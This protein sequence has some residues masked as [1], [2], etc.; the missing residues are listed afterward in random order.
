VDTDVVAAILKEKSGLTEPSDTLVQ[1]SDEIIT[2]KDTEVSD[3]DSLEEETE[4]IVRETLESTDSTE[5]ESS[6]EEDQDTDTHKSLQSSSDM[7]SDIGEDIST[8]TTPRDDDSTSDGNTDQDTYPP[9]QLKK[10]TT[11]SMAESRTDQNETDL[12]EP[13][14][15]LSEDQDEP[16]PVN[17]MQILPD[18]EGS[19]IKERHQ[20]EEPQYQE[21]KYVEPQFEN[22]Q[23]EE[24][25]GEESQE[26]EPDDDE[27]QDDNTGDAGNEDDENRDDKD[28]DNEP[29]EPDTEDDNGGYRV[30]M[31]RYRDPEIEF[32]E[33]SDEENSGDGPGGESKDDSDSGQDDSSPE[34]LVT[35]DSEF[36]ETTDRTTDPDVSEPGS[37]GDDEDSFI[38]KDEEDSN[39]D[40][41]HETKPDDPLQDDYDPAD[42]STTDESIGEDGEQ[43]VIEDLD[44]P[45]E[46]GDV[47]S[48][49][50]S[51]MSWVPEQEEESIPRK[52]VYEILSII[53][54]T[55]WEEIRDSVVFL[56]HLLF[57]LLIV[58]SGAFLFYLPFLNHF[59][60]K[61]MGIGTLWEYRQTTNMDGFLT[62][63]GLF[64]FIMAT[65]LVKW[66]FSVHRQRGLSHGRILGTGAI[67]LSIY[68]AAIF[69]FYKYFEIDY[70]VLILSIAMGL[71][72]LSIIFRGRLK[73]DQV[74][75][76]MLALVAVAITAGVE[77]FFIKDFYQGGDHRRFNTVFKF[78]LQAWFLLAIASAFLVAH[79]SKIS[80]NKPHS[81][82]MSMLR[83]FGGWIW[84]M[85]FFTL[86]A[87]A[88]IFTFQGPRARRH[89]DEYR[90]IDLP[91][92]LDGMAYMKQGV[93]KNEHRAIMWLN[94]NVK[95][96]PVILEVSGPDYQYKYGKISAN[97]GLPTVL[98]WW[99]HVDQREYKRNTG[100]MKRD[101]VTIY[102]SLDIPKVLDLL[103]MYN[104]EY[105]Y[106]GVT[107]K[108]EYEATGLEKF[109]DLTDYMTP[110]YANSDVT[111]YRVN[112]YG[113]NVD[114]A[115]VASD[116]DALEKLNQRLEQEAARKAEDEIK[117]EEARRKAMEKMK[118]RN[119]LNAGKGASR[120]MFEEP[121][122][123]DVDADGNVYVADFR[124]H[125]IQKFNKDGEWQL[126]WGSSGNG[127]GQFH[128]VC[129]VTVDSDGVYVADTF[130]NRIQKF[131][132]NGKFV[133]SWLG[134]PQ[135]YFYPRGITTDDKGYIYLSDTGNHRIVKLTNKG[136]YV[137]SW[138]KIGK[139][140]GQ[141]D[142]P[143]GICFKDDKLFVTDT[144]NFRIQVFNSEGQYLDAIKVD[145]WEGEIF[146]EPYIT[147]DKKNRI[148]VS[149]PTGNRI[150]VYNLEGKK[151]RSFK[152]SKQSRKPF[153]HPMGVALA[154][155]GDVLVVDTHNHT[156]AKI[157]ADFD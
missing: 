62:M 40:D 145:G 15:E 79:R 3:R 32:N 151:I 125:R 82:T 118:P 154:L 124:N 28:L 148:W 146:L 77:I 110:V 119:M 5:I 129:D 11:E 10:V 93:W 60:R 138:G 155:N 53:V 63:F 128:D 78:Y 2:A 66:W 117:A 150:L 96:T 147:L 33:N 14:Q 4:E 126:K 139:S 141:F 149:D 134:K 6:D 74:F 130:N 36:N 107:E 19:H 83:S 112:D 25:Q 34:E 8:I 41:S 86:F 105:I 135:T 136:K 121:R 30:I 143:V 64:I 51:D 43:D 12:R 27:S 102:N 17:P 137:K 116:S 140:T 1:D 89:H 94:R 108:A 7:V 61:G 59:N 114:F 120:G 156:L 132:H 113:L 21:P 103:R 75:V 91:L 69:G 90:R 22:V 18:E 115:K 131:D 72:I 47:D 92:T 31:E 98:G 67:I 80:Y 88:L 58:V 122:S 20:Y 100:R 157:S 52:S 54:N 95:G 73:N 45:E 55:I 123:L 35:E 142:G 144:K 50:S 106:I 13:E 99:S 111:I 26:T 101:I 42:G 76:L 109:A 57:P 87:S 71:T 70:S 46:S 23:D 37:S 38:V 104:I 16:D 39:I 84:T 68:S 81:R 65:Q 9:Y 44:D 56:W 152:T 48:I 49:S 133:A 127:P 85:V 24:S 29:T 97:T 153:I